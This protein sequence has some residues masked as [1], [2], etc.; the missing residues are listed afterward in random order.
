MLGKKPTSYNKKQGPKMP[1][2]GSVGLL[3]TGR[4]GRRSEKPKARKKAPS[5]TRLITGDTSGM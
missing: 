5:P 3:D 4:R 2:V 1:D